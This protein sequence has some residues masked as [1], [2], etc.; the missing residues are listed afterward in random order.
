M[1]GETDQAGVRAGECGGDVTCRAQR[2]DTGAKGARSCQS[3][4][5]KDVFHCQPR[6]RCSPRAPTCSRRASGIAALRMHYLARRRGPRPKVR[7]QGGRSGVCRRNTPRAGTGATKDVAAAS[8]GQRLSGGVLR[9]ERL[10]EREKDLLVRRRN[11][12]LGVL[13][14]SGSGRMPSRTRASLHTAPIGSSI[15]S[16]FS[17]K[18]GNYRRRE[19]SGN[20]PDERGRM[21]GRSLT[22]QIPDAKSEWNVGRRDRAVMMRSVFSHRDPRRMWRMR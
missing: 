12:C 10:G 1:P 15:A 18:T 2:A 16:A 13:A 19:R 3:R 11:R 8:M 4:F 14:R 5:S 7:Y 21:P 20:A 9:G 22:F 17:E 6:Y